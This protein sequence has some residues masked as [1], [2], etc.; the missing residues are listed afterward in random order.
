[1]ISFNSDGSFTY[2]PDLNY[3]GSDSFNYEVIDADGQVATATA[4]ISI[5]V[6]N[7]LPVVVSPIADQSDLDGDAILLDLSGTFTDPDGDPLVYSATG[8]PSG[9]AIDPITGVISGTIDNS[10]SAGGPYSVTVTVDDGNGGLMSDSFVWTIGNPAPTAVDDTYSVN[11]DN[12]LAGSVAGNDSDPDLDPMTFN[13]LAGPSDGTLTWNSDGT[14]T[15]TPSGDFHGTDS[16]T[17][18]I[19]DADGDVST[20]VATIIVAPVNDAPIANADFETTNEDNPV[21]IDVLSNDNDPDGDPLT[22]NVFSPPANGSVNVNPDGS[23]EYTPNADFNGTDTFEYEICDSDGV[24]ATATVSIVVVP[25]NDGPVA[26]DDSFMT[27]ED[28]PVLGSVATNDMDPEGDA[29]TFSLLTPPSSGSLTFHSDGTFVFVPDSNYNGTLSFDYEVIDSSGESDTATVTIQVN[30]VNDPP[31]ANDDSESTSEDYSVIVNLL[32]NDTDPENDLLQVI[33]INGEVVSPGD[34]VELGSGARVTLNTD[35]TAVYDPNGQFEDLKTG[36]TAID[37]FL[38]TIS[39]GHGETASAEAVITISGANDAPI[40]EDDYVTTTIN[41]PVEFPVLTNDTDVEFDDLAVVLLNNPPGGGAVVNPNGTIT[42]T[43]DPGFVGTVT[44]HYLIED[45]EGAS[46]DATMTIDVVRVF[47]FDSFTNFSK[48]N[49]SHVGD[50]AGVFH[51]ERLLSR[52]IF[53]L[54]PEPIFSGFAR[55]GTQ[56]VGRIY[57]SSGALVGEATANTDAGG[58]WMMQF[59]SAEGYEFYRI[60][61]E[62]VAAGAADVYGYFGLNPADNSYQSM[63]PL[64]V[65]DQP[66]SVEGAMK[67]SEMSLMEAQRQDETPLGFGK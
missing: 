37:T 13:L 24:C 23:I 14:F 8:L 67:T 39:D 66:L 61:F 47:S 52:E 51:R 55:P 45:P 30:P 5:G 11:E 20:A 28:I 56:I 64:T 10:A 53:S 34:S 9:L 27:S 19:V 60:E 33:E 54:A 46:S 15:Y 31:E 42:F 6:V 36:H 50:D 43:P 21:T 41:T 4:F 65:Y 48:S 2:V 16:F 58:N 32:G 3:N 18:Q 12:P 62:Q 7:D 22:V 25:V 35:G 1:M 17:Y 49:S 38:Y 44:L 63:E 26:L 59:H 57:D 29:L 40:A